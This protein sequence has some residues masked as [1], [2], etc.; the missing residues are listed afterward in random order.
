MR[1]VS[2]LALCGLLSSCSVVAVEGPPARHSSLRAYD[3]ST[4]RAPAVLDTIA[5]AASAASAG[6]AF[7]LDEH[8]HPAGRD[9]AAVGLV[10]AV[11]ALVY[12]GSAAF[13]YYATTQCREAMWGPKPAY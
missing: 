2:L 10:A 8:D 9:K 5:F 12:A 1:S 13:G 6:A 11:S 3:C 7:A 4:H